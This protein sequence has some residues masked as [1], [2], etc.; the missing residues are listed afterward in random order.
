[1][2]TIYFTALIA[3]AA[4]MIASIFFGVWLVFSAAIDVWVGVSFA[5]S[6]F[7]YLVA[8]AMHGTLFKSSLM[9]VQY[10][11][12]IPVFVNMFPLYSFCNMHDISWGTK[13]GNLQSETRR[14]HEG[15]AD[16]AQRKAEKAYEAIARL[17]EEGNRKKRQALLAARAAAMGWLPP[18]QATAARTAGTGEATTGSPGYKQPAQ[19]R[20]LVGGSGATPAKPAKASLIGGLT[21]ARNSI[22]YTSDAQA[23][24]SVIGPSSTTGSHNSTG[25]T[26]A[27]GTGEAGAGSHTGSAHSH[28]NG[29]DFEGPGSGEVHVKGGAHKIKVIDEDNL[30]EGYIDL[31]ALGP[32]DVQLN[33]NVNAVAIVNQQMA[34]LTEFDTKRL[35]GDAKKAAKAH[36]EAADREK[37]LAE[38]LALNKQVR[39]SGESFSC[40]CD[41]VTA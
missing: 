5:C 40:T 33:M 13:E 25:D 29:G 32:K 37:R 30:L 34:E 19:G 31:A 22:A 11:M 23:R 15:R 27:G 8:A 41:C 1:M 14:M 6:V 38:E 24:G 20:L 3:Y 12:L 21:G 39:P 35:I 16:R 10:I 9:F 36:Q 18:T 7:S 28:S 26:E 4:C 17:K 2:H